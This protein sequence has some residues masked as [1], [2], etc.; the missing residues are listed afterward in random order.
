MKRKISLILA[1]AVVMI[2][3]TSLFPVNCFAIADGSCTCGNPDALTDGKH[4]CD[5][6][7]N[8]PDDSKYR[9]YRVENNRYDDDYAYRTDST[10]KG[11]GIDKLKKDFE[12][13]FEEYP[14]AII[15]CIVLAILLA[16]FAIVGIRKGNVA[17]IYCAIGCATL[18]IIIVW[19][20]M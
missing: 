8:V 18:G 3:A 11:K 10:K 13:D 5:N 2:I 7:G 15:I 14:V 6:I 19:L 9:V 12:R 17:M 16:V 1:I 20:L 4:I